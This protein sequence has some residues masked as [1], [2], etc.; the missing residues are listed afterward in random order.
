MKTS[1][2]TTPSPCLAPLA[3]AALLVA[4]PGVQAGALLDLYNGGREADPFA[5]AAALEVKAA[6]QGVITQQRRYLPRAAISAREVW[7]EQDIKQSGN[8]VFQSGKE[9]YDNLRVTAEV[10]LPI[11]DPTTRPL[12]EAARARLRQTQGYGRVAVERQARQLVEGFVRATRAHSLALSSDRVIARLEKELDAVTKSQEAKIATVTDVQNIRLALAS[13]RRER[14]SFVQ[15]FNNELAELGAT[16][17]VSPAGWVSLDLGIDAA[18]LLSD[19]GAARSVDVDILRAQVDEMGHQAS[20][21]R[22]RTLPVLSLVG[23]Y[24]FDDAGGS[25]FGGPR[26]FSQYEFGVA[27][28]WAVFDRGMNYSEARE[29]AYRQRAKEA[30]LRAVAQE[31]DHGDAL[32]VK[33]LE[34][35]AASVA[36]LEELVEQ[37]KVLMIASARAYEAGQE[38]Y[39]NSI[40]AYLAYESAMRE[41]SNA[42]YDH[43]QRAVGLRARATG[44]DVALVGKV[45]AFFTAAK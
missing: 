40:T 36:E 15:Q 24:G 30:E 22:R 25:L 13:M 26:K 21:S 1:R 32:A 9:G 28:Q 20:A 23:Q 39:A 31:K 42:R 7:V 37:H 11:Y 29:H 12:I 14:N 6:E 44:W 4:V 3:L 27:V 33:I 17:E 5:R 41:L 16:G 2:K 19:A 10:E 38:S 45:D 35:S 34:Q 8:A 18:S 43:L